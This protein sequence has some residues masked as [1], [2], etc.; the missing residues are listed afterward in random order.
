M[1]TNKVSFLGGDYEGEIVAIVRMTSPGDPGRSYG[2]PED[3]YEGWGAEYEITGWIIEGRAADAATI[4]ALTGMTLREVE[5]RVL[6][7]ADGYDWTD[8]PDPDYLRDQRDEQD[9]DARWLE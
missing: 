9:E 4:P 1:T 6:A 8:E 3:C 5:D 7:D 2:R